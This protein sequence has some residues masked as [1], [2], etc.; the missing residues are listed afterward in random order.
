LLTCG[1]TSADQA[2]INATSET[3][4]ASRARPIRQ[5]L[6]NPRAVTYEADASYSEPVSPVSAYAPVDPHGP[7]ELLAGRGLY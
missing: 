1:N 2:S 4:A 6:A 7:S 3:A 5:A